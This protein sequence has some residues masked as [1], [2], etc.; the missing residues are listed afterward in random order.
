MLNLLKLGGNHLFIMKKIIFSFVFVCFVFIF[1]FIIG[2][3]TTNAYA[4]PEV[5]NVQNTTGNIYQPQEVYYKGQYYIVF[6]SGCSSMAVIK[7]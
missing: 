6:T 4:K 1:G 2:V 3:S 5:T 7:K